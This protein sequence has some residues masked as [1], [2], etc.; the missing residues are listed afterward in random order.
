[1]ERED[2]KA[3]RGALGAVANIA[4]L[5]RELG[6]VEYQRHKAEQRLAT[7]SLSPGEASKV[8]DERDSLQDRRSNLLVLLDAEI[9]RQ[10]KL[11][12]EGEEGE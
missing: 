10:A 4:V 7:G 8:R 12:A 1:M 5:E 2:R 11:R 3:R 9:A 6:M